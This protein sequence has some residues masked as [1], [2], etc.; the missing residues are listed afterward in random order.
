[1]SIQVGQKAPSFSLFNTEKQK[2]S[3]EEQKGKPVV[4]L[5][6]PLAFT[7][8]CP[9]ELCNVRDNIALYNNTNA[10]VFVI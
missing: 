8:V 5:F 6:F 2:V 4:L 10:Q 7:G 9:A 1:M 3:L